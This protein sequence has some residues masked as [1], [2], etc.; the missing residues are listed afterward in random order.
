V[1]P[2]LGLI[3]TQ[4]L[5]AEQLKRLALY[6]QVW[7]NAILHTAPA[8]REDVAENIGRLYRSLDCPPP[9]FVLWFDSPAEAAWAQCLLHLEQDQRF[10]DSYR[11]Q[12]SKMFRFGL[13]PARKRLLTMTGLRDWKVAQQSLVPPPK[14]ADGLRPRV[15]YHWILTLL[16]TQGVI[17]PPS[18]RSHLNS[19]SAG[20]DADEDVLREFREDVTG[21]F[22]NCYGAGRSSRPIQ[23]EEAALKI[24]GNVS[25]AVPM[26]PP[27]R[28][29]ELASAEFLSREC[30]ESIPEALLALAAIVKETS[31]FWGFSTAMVLCDQPTEIHRDAKGRLHREDGPALVYR[32]GWCVYALKGKR[33]DPL[34]FIEADKITFDLIQRNPEQKKLLV[35]R[36]GRDRYKKELA[37]WKAVPDHP[38]LKAKLPIIHRERIEFFQQFAKG[39]LPSYDRYVAGDRIAVWESLRNIDRLVRADYAMDAL[40]VAYETMERARTN[41]EILAQ[42]LEQLHYRFLNDPFTPPNATQRR[43]LERIDRR[44]GPL[45]ISLKAFYAVLGSV[46]FIGSH[47][48]LS[49]RSGDS[50]SPVKNLMADPLAVNPVE[51]GL[52]EFEDREYQGHR[53]EIVFEI[54]PDRFHKHD[55]SGGG[56][57]AFRLPCYKA[58][59][60]V[61]EEP[62]GLYFVEYLRL[63]FR[64]GGF[65]GFEAAPEMIPEREMRILTEG[66][67][68]I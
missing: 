3:R 23:L 15:Q 10:F 62:N 34:S 35:H 18:M 12:A 55:V 22:W 5:D 11:L 56:P 36:Y 60:I 46:D 28:H 50:E 38:I 57:Y 24:G 32:D 25:D 48:L 2:F 37:D 21:A 14:E 9:G 54:A 45:P 49:W 53:Q 8:N 51:S 66:L 16:R 59:A 68:D 1:I 44:P 58:D 17:R 39:L 27:L 47:T 7:R 64:Y 52:F 63:C 31:I 26:L 33:A 13:E 65:P 4:P 61:E 67:L 19:Q 42:R 40:A 43:E 41:V 20:S 30:G 6:R 29:G